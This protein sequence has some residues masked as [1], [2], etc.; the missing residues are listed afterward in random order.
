MIIEHSANQIKSNRKV[1]SKKRRK[2]QR[3]WRH[4]ASRAPTSTSCEIPILATL[5]EK[6]SGFRLPARKVIEELT[7][8][9]RQR[10]FPELSEEDLQ[11]GHSSSK[12]KIVEIAIRFARKNLELKE[13]LYR[14]SD[15][16]PAGVWGLAMKGKMRLGA[17]ANRGQ[18]QWKANYSIHEDALM[19]VETPNE[20]K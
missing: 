12:R 5:L 13:E 18:D 6:G 17:W 10:W 3:L 2:K 19:P 7:T 9:S 20:E 11:A 14:P 4:I 16:H 1:G 8:T 15:K